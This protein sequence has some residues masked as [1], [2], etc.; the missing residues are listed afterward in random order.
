MVFR[1]MERGHTVEQI[2]SGQGIPLNGARGYVRGVEE[3][4]SG[5]LPTAPW[6]ALNWARTTATCGGATYRLRFAAT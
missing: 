2:A 5:K 1:D 3:L 6:A 4:L